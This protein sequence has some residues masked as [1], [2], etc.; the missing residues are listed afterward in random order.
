M[1]T[2][3]SRLSHGKYA[4]MGA[5]I[6]PDRTPV[7]AAEEYGCCGICGSHYLGISTKQQLQLAGAS[8]AGRPRD[9]GGF[10]ILK[11]TELPLCVNHGLHGNS[12]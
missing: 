3:T 6:S 12:Q 5:I 1:T 2:V 9:T 4:L 8:H 11:G 7:I 10:G